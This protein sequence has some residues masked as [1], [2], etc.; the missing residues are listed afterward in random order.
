[1]VINPETATR[2][3][4]TLPHATVRAIEDFRFANRI[5]T[6][7]EAIRRLIDLGLA[8]APQTPTE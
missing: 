6:E 8:A 5:K 7:S 4:V 3:L 1:M 2:K